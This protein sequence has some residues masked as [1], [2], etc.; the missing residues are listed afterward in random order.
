MLLRLPKEINVITP[1][2]NTLNEIYSAVQ[3]PS[4]FTRKY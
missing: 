4:E 3:Q 2:Y 1:G